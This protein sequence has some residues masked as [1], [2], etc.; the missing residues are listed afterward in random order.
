MEATNICMIFKFR[1]FVMFSAVNAADETE[2]AVV[3]IGISMFCS[4][5]M[6]NST[7]TSHTESSV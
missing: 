6:V 3:I 7:P 1:L 5:H 4:K 2:Q